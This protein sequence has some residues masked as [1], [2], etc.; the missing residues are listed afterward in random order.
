MISDKYKCIFVHIIKTGGISIATALDMD[1]KQCHFYASDIKQLVGEKRWNDY[2]TFTF[3]RNPWDK[4]V[5]QYHYN[6]EKFCKRHCGRMLNFEEY[7]KL[8]IANDRIYTTF[9]PQ[10]LPYIIDGSDDVMVDFIGRFE[11]LEEDFAYICRRLD[12]VDVKLPQL[13]ISKHKHYS[14]FYNNETR[15]IIAEK[16]RK[17]IKHFNYKF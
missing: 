8:L 7:V 11:N 6:G 9:T 15:E 12:I 5:S 14:E 3:V 17:D 13:N 2:F 1:K 10:N 16:F 4:I